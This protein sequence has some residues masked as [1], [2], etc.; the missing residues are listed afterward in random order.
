M[1][2]GVYEDIEERHSQ[3]VT[4]DV[5]SLS[6]AKTNKPEELEAA[7]IDFTSICTILSF[8]PSHGLLSGDPLFEP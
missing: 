5:A 4:T 7:I 2:Q 3:S 8:R 1:N 6:L